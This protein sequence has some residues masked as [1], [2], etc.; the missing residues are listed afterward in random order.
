MTHFFSEYTRV[1]ITMVSGVVALYL[2]ITQIV[3]LPVA[4][5][6]GLEESINDEIIYE[7]IRTDNTYTFELTNGEDTCE[8][9]EYSFGF[10]SDNCELTK[11]ICISR[12]RRRCP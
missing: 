11:E 3:G 9:S 12:P 4:E 10:S 1:I 5:R 2:F 8:G 7:T 6:L